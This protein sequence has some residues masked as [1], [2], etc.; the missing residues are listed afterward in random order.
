VSSSLNVHDVRVTVTG[1]NRLFEDLLV[2]ALRRRGFAAGTGEE[3]F[4]GDEPDVIIADEGLIGPGRSGHPP[5]VLIVERDDGTNG[6][7]ARLVGARACVSRN[8][9]AEELATAVF[10]VAAG[11]DLLKHGETQ[12]NRRFLTTREIDVLRLM[13]AGHDNA[14]IAQ[15]LDISPHTARTH[16][17][18][19]LTKFDVRSRFSAVSAARGQGLLRSEA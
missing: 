12:S 10:R 7:M 4:A 3:V 16:V 8:S 11:E 14:A 17:Q 15:K 1:A 2:A 5:C 19:I 9:T 13:A 6:R 18:R